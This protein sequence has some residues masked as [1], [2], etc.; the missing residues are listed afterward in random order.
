MVNEAVSGTMGRDQDSDVMTDF[1]PQWVE[2]Y[3]S[4]GMEKEAEIIEQEISA[5]AQ[6]SPLDYSAQW[7][8]YYRYYSLLP[9]LQ[10]LHS[11]SGLRLR[12]SRPN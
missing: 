10:I 9:L 8:Q 11:S 4:L 3:R 7:A 6:S 2:Y 12:Q 5:R 1:R